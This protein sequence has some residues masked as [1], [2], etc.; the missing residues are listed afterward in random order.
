MLYRIDKKQNKILRIK[1][2]SFSEIGFK[3]RQHIQEWIRKESSVFG[4]E[5]LIIQKEF[6]DFDGTAERLDLLG[7]DKQGNGFHI[8]ECIK[9]MVHVRWCNYLLLYCYLFFKLIKTKVSNHL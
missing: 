7:L 5:I 8:L 4:E 3:E 9:Y 2:I 1:N 6:A